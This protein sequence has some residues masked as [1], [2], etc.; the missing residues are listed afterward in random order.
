VSAAL[1][2]DFSGIRLRLE[3]LNPALDERLRREWR[4]FVAATGPDP[5]LRL[6][7]T[8]VEGAAPQGAFAPKAM[9]SKLERQRAAFHM[10]EGSAAVFEDGTGEI[11][12]LRGLGTREYYSFLNF[13]RATLAWKLPSRGGMLMHAAGLVVG[14][15]GFIM[16]GAEGS[17]KSSWAKLGESA[18]CRV[19]SD[20]L[21]VLDGAGAELEVLGA[22]FRSTHHA[23][24]RP[25]RWPLAAVLFP[26]HAEQA[27]LKPCDALIARARLVANLTFIAE[28]VEK[29]DRISPMLERLTSSVPCADLAFA[30]DGSFVELLRGWRGR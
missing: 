6:R 28:A 2:L 9:T 5:F 20:D 16:V 29:D 14:E 7:L 19:L 22:P 30:L 4:S 24:Y 13:L 1:E 27:A 11:T 8:F 10:A 17:G 18:G 12:L 15:R 21:V 3:N 25:G 23:D 26:R